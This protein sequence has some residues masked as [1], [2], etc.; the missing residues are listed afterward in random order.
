MTEN[1]PITFLSNIVRIATDIVKVISVL[2]LLYTIN[3]VG[4]IYYNHEELGIHSSSD[5]IAVL[6]SGLRFDL[7]GILMTN[8]L[9]LTIFLILR[10]STFKKL[11]YRVLLGLM[12]ITNGIFILFNAID[13]PYFPFSRKRL[14]SEFFLF[15][16]G[17][18][19]EEGLYQLPVFIIDYG[20]IWLIAIGLIYFL[21]KYLSKIIVPINLDGWKYNIPKAGIAMMTVLLALTASVVGIRGGLQLRP[22]SIINATEMADNVQVPAVLNS[23]FSLLRTMNKNGLSEVNYIDMTCLNPL[24]RGI[25]PAHSDKILTPINVVIVVVESLSFHYLS[26]YGGSAKTPFLDSL[27]GQ[28]LV[29]THAYANAKESVQGIPAIVA[30]IPSWMEE[31]FIFSKYSTN[32]VTSLPNLLKTKNYYSAFFHGAGLGTM[33][34]DAF[35]K[36]AG[37]DRYYSKDDYPDQSQFDGSWGI[38]DEPFLKYSVDQMTVMKAPF[39]TT[40]FTINSHHPFILP[41]KYQKQFKQ[42]G[43][44]ILSSIRY[45]DHALRQFF[46]YAKTK[47]WYTNTIFVITADHAGPYT[48]AQFTSIED[49]HVPIVFY[50]PNIEE[51]K[52]DIRMANQIDILATILDL[53]EY[54]LPY[55]SLGTSLID[56]LS[57][58]ENDLAITYN[59]GIYEAIQYP[60]CLI[61]NGEKSISLFDYHQ[62]PTLKL[63][64]ISDEKYLAI[65][66]KIEAIAKRKIQV[67]NTAMIENTMTID[68]K[69]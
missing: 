17:D 9:W 7:S 29:F 64:L 44:P 68:R 60:Y 61:F 3:R 25:H 18:K 4:F 42:D 14:Q 34:F 8:G 59:S 48:G 27:L 26:R 32:A 22:L 67:F 41:T 56:T 47:E 45:V 15:L 63:N 37:F 5:L 52:E 31:S 65:A 21:Y 50:N 46:A 6:L 1:P 28:S 12:M 58:R 2:M 54:P 16:T 11:Y 36:S 13:I 19:G 66:K 39:F 49:H 33:S 23:T 62:D 35:C 24:D 51:G 20:L 38:W 55:F 69:K 43:H 40:I 30:S 53:I 10:L 57:V